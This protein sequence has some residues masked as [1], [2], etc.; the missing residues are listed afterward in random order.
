MA[1]DANAL[2][3]IVLAKGVGSL[4]DNLQNVLDAL[5][6]VAVNERVERPK[7]EPHLTRLRKHFLELEQLGCVKLLYRTERGAAL[8]RVTLLERK[9]SQFSTPRKDT[10]V[11]ICK[12]VAMEPPKQVTHKPA[13]IIP[14]PRCLLFIDVPNICFYV[15]NKGVPEE[16]KLPF[17]NFYRADWHALRKIICT[18]TDVPMERQAC[19]MY[20]RTLNG[21]ATKFDR[22]C[23]EIQKMGIY[24][25]ARERKD[26]D[27]MLAVDMVLEMLPYLKENQH[28]HLM[29]VSGD[30]D[31]AYALKRIRATARDAKAEVTLHVM[32]W[33]HTQSYELKE[34]VYNNAYW[35]DDYFHQ[36]IR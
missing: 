31:Y 3:K 25:T 16:S 30:S 26:V 1:T 23:R 27:E 5:W 2:K 14:P 21:D 8:A 32:S 15:N 29:L 9:V 18:L 24:L 13:K 33:R 34:L 20:V 4:W 36:L 35:L 11:V 19:H 6:Q 12:P 28:V 22:H 7:F 17:L 10:A